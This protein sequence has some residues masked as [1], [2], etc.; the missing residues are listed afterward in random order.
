MQ[1]GDVRCHRWV[2]HFGQFDGAE[3]WKFVDLRSGA[4]DVSVW[5]LYFVYDHGPQLLDLFGGDGNVL[6]AVEVVQ[7]LQVVVD[8]LLR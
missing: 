8:S 2:L 1:P 6:S 7:V 3:L 5:S 4:A